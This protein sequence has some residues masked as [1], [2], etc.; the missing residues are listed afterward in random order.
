MGPRLVELVIGDG[1]GSREIEDRRLIEVKFGLG[2]APSGG[3]L[4]GAMRQVEIK[5]DAL[6]GRGKGDEGNDPHLAL[7]CGAQEREHLV[8]GCST[9]RLLKKAP[10]RLAVSG[11]E[12]YL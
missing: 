9:R 3:D 7:V 4:G 1:L 11:C 6:Y 2:R 10:F 8:D 5:E 12:G